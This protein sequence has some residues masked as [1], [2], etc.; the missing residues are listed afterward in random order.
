MENFAS[1]LKSLRLAKGESRKNVAQSCGISQ[2]S[3]GRY[4]SD[5][6][7]PIL[8]I[9]IILADY[10]EMSLDELVGRTEYANKFYVSVLPFD[11]QLR[12]L[13]EKR[14][15]T[16]RGLAAS[17]DK[18]YE[19]IRK[20]LY[21]ANKPDFDTL[22]RLADFFEVPLGKLVGHEPKPKRKSGKKK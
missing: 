20:Y 21:G 12:E 8:N 16:Q 3:Y 14:G 6:T 4:E 7:K 19:T 18:S 9:L 22:I 13:I 11:K 10:Y 5:K 2:G 15:I 17:V 1:R